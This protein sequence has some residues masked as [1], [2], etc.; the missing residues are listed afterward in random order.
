[1]S[2]SYVVSGAKLKCSCGDKEC[3]FQPDDRG[4]KVDDLVQGNSMD[5]KPQN[6]ASFG[7]CKSMNNPAVAAATASNFGVLQQMPCQ[8]VLSPW[9]NGKTNKMISGFPAVVDSSQVFCAY[10]GVIKVVDC[11]QDLENTGGKQF[12][13]VAKI[14]QASKEKGKP[15]P[16]VKQ[17]RQ[18]NNQAFD[19]RDQQR[20]K[21][22]EK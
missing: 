21:S 9:V 7:M 11:G 22:V 15:S 20:A 16:A 10:A 12:K 3:T 14:Q 4:I 17:F 13:D 1:M 8:P 6:I 2:E 19:Q 18:D 5:F